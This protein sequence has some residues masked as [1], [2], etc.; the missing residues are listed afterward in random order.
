MEVV[1]A[2]C[3]RDQARGDLE[4]VLDELPDHIGDVDCAGRARTHDPETREE[5]AKTR[6]EVDRL[7]ELP[8]GIREKSAS[9][10]GS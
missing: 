4:Q 5:G 10:K 8:V 1:T 6:R 9:G 2:P 7:P 3:R